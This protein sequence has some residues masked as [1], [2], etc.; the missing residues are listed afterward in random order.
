MRRGWAIMT[1]QASSLPAP[2]GFQGVRSRD[3]RV[4]VQTSSLRRQLQ[5]ASG[6]QAGRVGS[7]HSV[8]HTPCSTLPCTSSAAQSRAPE[9][10]PD[11]VPPGQPSHG[12]AGRGAARAACAPQHSSRMYWGTCVDLPQPVAP[13]MSTTW[14]AWMASRICCLAR[15]GLASAAAPAVPVRARGVP[16]SQ[17]QRVRQ[18]NGTQL[19]GK[20][21]CVISCSGNMQ[22]SCWQWRAAP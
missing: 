4:R 21:T 11:T 16:A 9:A 13:A 17:A 7:L 6:A 3:P 15:T 20:E 1:R 12:A 14:C 18:P 8:L 10:G 22:G 2:S 5:H 19:V